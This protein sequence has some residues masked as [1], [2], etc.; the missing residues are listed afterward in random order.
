[1]KMNRLLLVEDDRTIALGLEYSLAEEGFS[2]RVCHD[3]ASALAAL[4]EETFVLAVLDLALPDGDGYQVCREIKTRG[5]TPVI[6]LTA[7][8]DEVNVVMGLDMGGDDYITK[9][10]R[11]RELISRIRSVLRRCQR[12]GGKS[13]L[14]LGPLR[15]NPAQARVW[16]NGSELFLSALEYRLLLTLVSNEGRVLTRS[17]LLEGIWDV[18]GEF[19][20]DNTLTVYIKRLREKVEDDPQLPRLIHTL[21]GL[22][23]KAGE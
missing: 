23:Y 11:V 18:G 20:N 8:D 14:T 4:K 21:R 15:I 7:W 9:P 22:G 10:F 6:F 2:V 13:E 17:Q 16:K 5:E 12:I 19:V 1:M 3:V